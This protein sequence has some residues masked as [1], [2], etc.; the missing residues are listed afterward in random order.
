M[1]AGAVTPAARRREI[2]SICR[3]FGILLLEDDPYYYLQWP[4][5]AAGHSSGA[6]GA[7]RG[8]ANLGTSYLSMDTD[9][10]VVRL[11]SFSK[12]QACADASFTPASICR[13]WGLHDTVAMTAVAILKHAPCS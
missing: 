8:L 6:D 1:H 10:R 3:E 7:P 5:A 11:D 13:G 2:Y 12:V 9:G 4:P